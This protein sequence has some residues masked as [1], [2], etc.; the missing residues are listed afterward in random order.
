MRNFSYF[1]PSRIFFGA[2]SV[3]KLSRAALPAGKGLIITG[4]TSTRKLG[5]VDKVAQALADGG[6]ETIVYAD[7][8]P[9]PT[10]EGVRACAALA[11]E[12][13]CTFVVGLGG[14]SSIEYRQGEQLLWR[15]TTATVGLCVRRLGQGPEDPQP[16]ASDCC[17]HHHSRHGHRSRPVDGHHQR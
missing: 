6:H 14:G 15:P 7:V 16:R 10:I 4:G 13:G 5:Y 9:N 1:M 3:K 2:G 11:R 8:Q 17:R 12:Q